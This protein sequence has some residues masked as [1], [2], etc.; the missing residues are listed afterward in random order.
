ML[1]PR[2]SKR[3]LTSLTRRASVESSKKRLGPSLAKSIWRL[4]ISGDWQCNPR[5]PIPW[6][7]PVSLVSVCLV[8]CCRRTLGR[9]S[10]PWVDSSLFAEWARICAESGGLRRERG[11]TH[12]TSY[13]KR[14][15]YQQG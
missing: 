14:H 3:S 6:S 15:D 7:E 4:E 10:P 8:A 12:T 5:L 13:G 1:S 9:W 2:C 11:K